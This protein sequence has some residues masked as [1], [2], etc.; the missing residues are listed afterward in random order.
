MT[1]EIPEITYTGIKIQYIEGR[2]RWVFELRGKDRSAETLRKAKDA[3]DK[4]APRDKSDSFTPFDAMIQTYGGHK[5]CRVTS[6]AEYVYGA[7]YFWVVCDG[8]RSKEPE[9]MLF[10]DTKANRYAANAISDLNNKA[11]KLKEQAA[12]IKLSP[13][14][15]PKTL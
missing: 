12:E 7:H 14:V 8:K 15:W 3:I 10:A 11:Q 4:P 9:D 5:P 1:N 2:D 13:I 6:M